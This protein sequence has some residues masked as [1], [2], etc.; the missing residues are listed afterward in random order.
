[1]LRW[2]LDTTTP[3]GWPSTPVADPIAAARARRCIASRRRKGRWWPACLPAGRSRSAAASRTTL[4]EDR[5]VGS[6]W[7]A[8]ATLAALQRPRTG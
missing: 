5:A 6:G 3:W 8:T 2:R 7:V 1:M 4:I